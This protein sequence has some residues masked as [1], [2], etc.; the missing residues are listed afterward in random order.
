MFCTG[1]DGLNCTP[2][3]VR[4]AG[5][6]DVAASQGHP[7]EDFGDLGGC[8]AG[9]EDDLGHAGAQGAV[10]VELGEA[11]VFKGKVF[12]AI[13]GIA[14][15]NAAVADFV[16]EGFEAKTIHWFELLVMRPR[17]LVA[18]LGFMRAGTPA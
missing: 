4:G 6:E 15:G 5:C 17:D 18:A 13:E 11:E 14:D 3:F 1:D 8:F 10:V 9:G 2:H 12:E 7:A 16:E